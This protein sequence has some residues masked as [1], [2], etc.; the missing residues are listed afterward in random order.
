MQIDSIFLIIAGQVA[1]F[2]VGL[3]AYLIY[4]LISEESRWE[5][6]TERLKHKIRE[7]MEFKDRFDVV[8]EN[9]HKQMEVTA[10]LTDQLEEHK[11]SIIDKDNKITEQ[12]T[13]ITDLQQEIE[14]LADISALLEDKTKLL[15]KTEVTINELK[16]QLALLEDQNGQLPQQIYSLTQ[17]LESL[18]TENETLKTNLDDANET[19]TQLKHEAN[20]ITDQ[21]DVTVGGENKPDA[22]DDYIENIKHRYQ[23]DVDRLRKNYNGQKNIIDEL[24]ASLMAAKNN[25]N[26]PLEFD[27][28][29]LE[30]LKQMLSESN[31]VIEMLETEIDS[32][33]NQL[34]T[35]N[36]DQE[37]V[38][39]QDQELSDTESEDVFINVNTGGDDVFF[40]DDVQPDDFSNQQHE[41]NSRTDEELNQL[42]AQLDSANQMAMSMMMTSGDQSNIINLARNIIQF[43]NL[44]DLGKGIL[45]T[46]GLFQ[47]NA[48]IQIRG[49]ETNILNLSSF[50]K[51]SEQDISK[52]SDL[53][54]EERFEEDGQELLIRYKN[55]SLLIKD[56]PLDDDEKIGRVK[57]NLAIGLELCSAELESIE[58]TVKIKKN[59]KL[60]NRVLKNTYD[61]IQNVEE[62][63][64]TQNQ[65]MNQVFNSLVGI[66]ANPAMT[67]GMDPIYR[68]VFT[69][70]IS[71]G[72]N[73]FDSFKNS[74]VAI[75]ATFS[76]IVKRLGSKIDD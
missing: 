30:R 16:T 10:D 40:S 11:T 23:A 8:T 63:F 46:V 14:E 17:D 37:T 31:T 34:L 55:I 43:D 75:D 50:E 6:Y 69:G 66:V 32:L 5:D 56:L 1:L 74:G 54:S 24:E 21:I 59:Q 68:D 28:S 22:G 60:L 18:S 39:N 3:I 33:Q 4:T 13:S 45:E 27:D 73:Q 20:K 72:K 49:K 47:V 38:L 65:N 57:D 67:Q 42:Q 2:M 76:D 19:I 26:K 48:A 52:I 53:S 51:L 15:D 12:L 71:D 7:L 70:I 58:T 62:Q 29:N 36:N 44:E 61:T 64:N 35:Q 25:P 9:L 41:T